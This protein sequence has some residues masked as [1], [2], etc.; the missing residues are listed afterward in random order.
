MKPRVHLKWASGPTKITME[1]INNYASLVPLLMDY[2]SLAQAGAYHPQQIMK[3]LKVNK[4][5]WRNSVRKFIYPENSLGR[6]A[7][8]STGVTICTDQRPNP[9]TGEPIIMSIFVKAVDD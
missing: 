3:D 4:N 6:R 1:N 7:L 5:F 9:V 2:F 8:A